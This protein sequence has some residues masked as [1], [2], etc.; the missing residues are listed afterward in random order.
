M[1][2][3][4]EWPHLPH[5]YAA[6]VLSLEQQ[7]QTQAMLLVD[8]TVGSIVPVSTER[9]CACVIDVLFCTLRCVVSRS[10]RHLR[11]SEWSEVM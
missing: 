9:V 3:T 5:R 10:S 4:V 7:Q 8:E 1:H 2:E 11:C 6:D